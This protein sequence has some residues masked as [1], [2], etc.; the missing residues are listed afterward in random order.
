[1]NT[2]RSTSL[3]AATLTMALLAGCGGGGDGAA[4][5]LPQTSS[6]FM[7]TTVQSLLDYVNGLI[8]RTDETSEPQPLGSAPL[9]TDD[10]L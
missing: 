6:V 4:P 5:N 2:R 10:T 7:G 3:L 8:A 9:P 1:M